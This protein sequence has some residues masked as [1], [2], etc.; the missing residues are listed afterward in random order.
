MGHREQLE[1]WFG[2]L[3]LEVDDLLLLER[4]QLLE[5][6]VRAPEPAFGRVLASDQ[7]LRRFIETRCPELADWLAERVRLAARDR[8]DPSEDHEA[9]VWELADWLVYQRFPEA[10]DEVPQLRWNAALLGEICELEG[11]TIVDAGAGTGWLGV[12]LA[13]AAEAVFAVE[14]VA[15]LRELIARRAASAGRGNVFVLDGMLDRIPL[16]DGF[17]DVLVTSRAI[18]WRLDAELVEVERV[19]A[20]TGWAVHV[21]GTPVD[22]PRT[23]VHEVLESRGYAPSPYLDAG[24]WRQRYAKQI[25]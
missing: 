18:G 9:L 15:R 24:Q 1:T 23:S 21:L 25:R 7:R 2:H 22:G 10:Y 13:G 11:R 20:P 8:V 14:P 12:A 5:L 4:F 3:P 19:V 16:P 6:P 17:A